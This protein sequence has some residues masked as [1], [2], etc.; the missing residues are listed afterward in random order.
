MSSVTTPRYADVAVGDALPSLDLP[1]V[2]RAMLAVYCGASG[3]H[4]PVH[5]DLDFARASGLDDVIAH[6]MLVM[7]WTGRVLTGWVPQSAIVSFDTRFLAVTRIGDAI[8][9]RGE[10]IEKFV[11]GERRCVRVAVSAVDQHG[12]TK[13]SGSAIVA[14][15]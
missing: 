14:L 12:E 7:A 3:D 11:D 6:G 4:N 15:A 1:P 8:T 9:A 5:V 10:V 13:T 2:T